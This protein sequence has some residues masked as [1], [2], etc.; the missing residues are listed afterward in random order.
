MSNALTVKFFCAVCTLFLLLSAAAQ[1]DE[2]D[3]SRLQ[4]P[5][6]A[7]PGITPISTTANATE[8]TGLGEKLRLTTRTIK[9]DSSSNHWQRQPP[10]GIVLTVKVPLTALQ[11]GWRCCWIEAYSHD[12]ARQLSAQIGRTVLGNADDLLFDA[13]ATESAIR[14]I[15]PGVYEVPLQLSSRRRSGNQ[16]ARLYVHL[17]RSLNQGS[18][19]HEHDGHS[20]LSVAGYASYFV[21]RDR[22]ARYFLDEPVLNVSFPISALPRAS[23]QLSVPSQLPNR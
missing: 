22:E 14:Q 16:P 9:M 1:A 4:P 7:T 12:A 18:A 19:H 13:A 3:N 20:Q 10:M 21:Q 17:Y 8:T 23:Q 5:S 6:I 2:I 15:A 11:Q